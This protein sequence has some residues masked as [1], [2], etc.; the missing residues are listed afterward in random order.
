MNTALVGVISLCGG[1]LGTITTVEPHPRLSG[2]AS[3]A[4][5]KWGRSELGDV[6]NQGPFTCRGVMRMRV[7][8]FRLHPRHLFQTK[9][10]RGG[11]RASPDKWPG[12]ESGKVGCLDW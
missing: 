3:P 1:P 10:V 4:G 12:I 7:S 2:L 11:W 9:S 8:M 5:V 6:R